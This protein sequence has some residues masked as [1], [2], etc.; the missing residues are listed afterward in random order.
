M[1]CASPSCS[2]SHPPTQEE[3]WATPR[4]PPPSTSHVCTH[5][6]TLPPPPF[7][8]AL[9]HTHP[10]FLHTHTHTP[11]QSMSHVTR[12]RKHLERW[13]NSAS[14]L[15]LYCLN[16]GRFKRNTRSYIALWFYHTFNSSL[17]CL[18]H[19]YTTQCAALHCQRT[20]TSTGPPLLRQDKEIFCLESML[21]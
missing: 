21:D 7:S 9:T 13:G 1:L 19:A 17:C 18:I 6:R 14:P 3:T 15:I 16:F 4:L 8:L 12:R 2:S 5:P 10:P 11:P 20:Q